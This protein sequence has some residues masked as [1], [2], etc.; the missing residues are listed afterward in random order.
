VCA[1][2]RRVEPRFSFAF[3]RALGLVQGGEFLT[4]EL[5]REDAKACYEMIAKGTEPYGMVAFRWRE[6]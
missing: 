6:G 4:H 1:H 3:I 5:C 2:H